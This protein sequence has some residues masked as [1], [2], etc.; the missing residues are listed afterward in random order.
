MKEIKNIVPKELLVHIGD[1]TVSFATLESY[2]QLVFKALVD[3][4]NIEIG[5]I[6]GTYLYFTNLRAELIS[7][8]KARHGEDTNYHV[9][10]ELM[11]KAG[12]IEE[13]RNRITH[14]SWATGETPDS[15]T[16]IKMTAREKHGFVVQVQPYDADTLSSFTANIRSLSDEIFNFWMKL[17]GIDLTIPLRDG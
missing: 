15:V 10:K 16:R 17:L 12:K 3:K 9:L 6:L 1:M 5:D 14:S 13:E 8:Y 4:E 7:L 2:M 11:I